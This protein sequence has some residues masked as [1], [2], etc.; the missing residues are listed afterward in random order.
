MI[1]HPNTNVMGNLHNNKGAFGSSRGIGME[2][3]KGKKEKGKRSKIYK[4]GTERHFLRG[5]TPEA[6]KKWRSGV[7]DKGKGHASSDIHD[8]GEV[9]WY[10]QTESQA[11]DEAQQ[12]EIWQVKQFV[13]RMRG[14]RAAQG[15]AV[16]DNE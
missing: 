11:Q 4:S 16:R 1:G 12:A 6:Q 5:S 9:N 2:S 14:I 8:Y 3:R 10:K 13:R 15:H 7:M